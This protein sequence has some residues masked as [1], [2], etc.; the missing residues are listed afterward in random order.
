MVSLPEVDFCDSCNKS[1]TLGVDTIYRCPQCKS[2]VCQRC[3]T[4]CISCHRPV[5]KKCAPNGYCNNASCQQTGRVQTD[6]S[7][8]RMEAKRIYD[9]AR[10]AFDSACREV[11]SKWKMADPSGAADG[12]VRELT[13]GRSY[14]DVIGKQA[15]FGKDEVKK[16]EKAYSRYSGEIM[17]DVNRLKP[18]YEAK[19]KAAADLNKIE[20]IT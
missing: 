15:R 12:W 4:S 14:S 2:V 13:F 8:R 10:D 7:S 16:M 6:K 17:Q 9:A 11:F 18:L 3:Y 5:C 20:G 19:E 1:M